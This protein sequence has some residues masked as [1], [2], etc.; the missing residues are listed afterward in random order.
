[1]KRWI[2]GVLLGVAL[3]LA[4]AA[5]DAHPLGNFT[6][7]HY[8]GVV[9]RPDAVILDYVID[10]AEIPTFQERAV[11]EAD[12]ARY[13]RDLAAGIV[14][15]VDEHRIEPLPTTTRLTSRCRRPATPCLSRSPLRTTSS[16]SS[17]RS[18]SRWA[19]VRSTH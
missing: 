10:M 6:I 16:V 15:R 8:L 18:W 2:A 7:N 12:P 3:A 1:M 14:V 11:I 19:S 5:A 13:C 9:V 4:P 17:S